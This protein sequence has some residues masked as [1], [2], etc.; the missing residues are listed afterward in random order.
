MV[1][2]T[3]P[4][5]SPPNDVKEPCRWRCV[6][7]RANKL[8]CCCPTAFDGPRSGNHFIGPS[9]EPRQSWP[10]G[11]A[12]TPLANGQIKGGSIQRAH[13]KKG[14]EGTAAIVIVS[15]FSPVPFDIL[16]CVQFV[17]NTVLR[18]YRSQGQGDAQRNLERI[19][20]AIGETLCL[21]GN[22]GRAHSVPFDMS[23]PSQFAVS[24]RTGGYRT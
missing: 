5:S 11:G 13:S 16:E 9:S 14:S 6:Q 18:G 19:N 4:F 3:R 22:C 21:Y 7:W 20:E 15:G 23:Q 1:T 24:H 10:Y 8:N 17:V 12:L 2:G